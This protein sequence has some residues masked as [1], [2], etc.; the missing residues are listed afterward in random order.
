MNDIANI[1]VSIIVNIILNIVLLIHSL[2]IP[3][4]FLVQ[5]WATWVDMDHT[6]VVMG[7]VWG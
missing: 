4:L 2:F 7:Y 6:W 5:S 1:I 3:S